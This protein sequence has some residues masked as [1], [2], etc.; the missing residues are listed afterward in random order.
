MTRFVGR[1]ILS[2]RE[3]RYRH[4]DYDFAV[5]ITVQFPSGTIRVLNLADEIVLAQDRH[6]GPVEEHLHQVVR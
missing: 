1:R 3:V 6:L 2:V 4:G 5:G